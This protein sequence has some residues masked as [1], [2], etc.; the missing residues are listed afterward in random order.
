MNVWMPVAVWATLLVSDKL[1]LFP[2]LY[3]LST[4]FNNNTTWFN[5]TFYLCVLRVCA[6]VCVCVC[7]CVCVCVRAYHPTGSIPPLHCGPRPRPGPGAG[8]PASQQ[9]PRGRLQPSK[10]TAS[11]S[12]QGRCHWHQWSS[13]SPCSGTNLG[14]G[15]RAE[16]VTELRLLEVTAV[17]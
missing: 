2:R 1:D 10:G 15:D 6:C 3:G 8:R 7:A 17:M 14:L 16:I 13:A 4:Y 9:R 5:T 11:Y 12:T